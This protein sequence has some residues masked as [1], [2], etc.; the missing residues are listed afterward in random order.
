MPVAA[1]IK[2]WYRS[3]GTYDLNDAWNIQ[4]YPEALSQA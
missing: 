2:I 1:S 4:V 3:H